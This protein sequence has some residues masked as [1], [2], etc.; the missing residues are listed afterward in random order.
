MSHAWYRRA[1]QHFGID[2]PRMAVRSHLPWPWRFALGA[3]VVAIVA[4][5]WWWGF[6]FGQI[7]GGFNRR[8]VEA[9]IAALETQSD[10][11]ARESAEWRTRATRAESDLAMTQATLATMSK[12]ALEQQNDAT[13]LKEELAF[14]RSL[15]AG[16]GRQPGVTIER[17]AVER[18]GDRWRYHLLIV[19][20]GNPRDDFQGYVA[21]SIA[22]AGGDEGGATG[23]MTLPDD[24]PEQSAALKLRFKYYQRVEGSF[25]VPAGATPRSLTVRAFEAGSAMPRATRNANIS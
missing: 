17:V 13:Q 5:M 12:Q 16:S 19:R 7:F 2:A 14:L 1:R 20:G 6:D 9:R 21:L 23:T 25:R 24:Q 10:Q 3:L 15:V 22:F 18:D 11:L 8:E 4:G